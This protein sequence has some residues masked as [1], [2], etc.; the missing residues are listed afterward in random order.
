ME[1]LLKQNEE[2]LWLPVPPADFSIPREISTDT[3]DVEGFGEISFIGKRKLQTISINS[4]FPSEAYYF[5][6][7]TDFP[8]PYACVNLI[9]NW[10]D[11]GIPIR[12]IISETGIN[13]EC[14]IERFEYGEKDGTGDV[15][16]QLDL[17]EYRRMEAAE[18]VVGTFGYSYDKVS[19]N[20]ADKI[21]NTTR[22]VTR[23]VPK[24]YTVK[25]GDTLFSIAKKF[26]GSIMNY[27]AIADK[28]NIKNTDKIYVG[29][30]LNL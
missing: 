17:K 2:S 12:L 18:K 24:T 6:Q 15:D 26:T 5:C 11:S 23:L 19:I 1:F 4:F 10:Q 8:E 14:S 9:S 21:I 28:N 22:P 30:V 20:D 29:Q 7:Y 3:F 25:Y 27:K 13:M 16:F